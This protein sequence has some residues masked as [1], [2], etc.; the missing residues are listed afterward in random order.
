M[1]A[2]SDGSDAHPISEFGD[3]FNPQWSP[4]ARHVLAV[5]E[6]KGGGQP[7]V[8]ILDPSGRD[9]SSSFTL[10]DASGLG[11][12]DQSSWQRLAR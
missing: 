12:A 1:I 7:I 4:D 8:A 11:R 9:P 2:N 6:R 5:D 3:W 10:P